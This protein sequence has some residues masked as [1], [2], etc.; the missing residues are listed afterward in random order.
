[1]AGTQASV[2]GNMLPAAGVTSTTSGTSGQGQQLM[3]NTSTVKQLSA[4]FME[5]SEF[6]VVQMQ[7]QTLSNAAVTN[8]IINN[9]GLG[10]SLELLV[11]GVITITNSNAGAQT[12][13]I[14]PEFPF[15][16][17]QNITVQ[18]NGQTVIHS[19]SG[20]ELLQIMSKRN[21][22][23]F[24]GEGSSAGVGYGQVDVRVPKALATLVIGGTGT[25]T[26]GNNI[27]GCASVSI[28]QGAATFTFSF[29]L[30][31]PFVFNSLD[32]ILIGL[33]PLQNNSVNCNVSIQCPTILG[34][35]ALAPLYGT[36]TY[37]TLT[38]TA[39]N[40]YPQYNFWAIPVPNNQKLYAWLTS[41]NYMLLS[42]GSNP[43]NNVGAKALN[44]SLPNNYF[45][46]AFVMIIRDSTTALVDP[47]SATVGID[48]LTLNYNGTAYIDRRKELMR[49]ARQTYYQNG[50]PGSLGVSLFD[51]TDA[52]AMP[53]RLNTSKWLNMYLSN[54]PQIQADIQASFSTVGT[55][56]VLREQLVPSQVQTV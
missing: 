1:M 38:S 7:T 35:T 54:N 14:S 6:N 3:P 33:L 13:N 12:L 43:I 16:L 51:L 53:N 23:M 21:K 4:L 10:Q 5:N 39:I 9:I 15:N 52:E 30:E 56:S 45:L 40:I 19:L 24:V 37:L 46:T 28:A 49:I 42:Q 48:N 31:L 29:Y 26:A 32:G 17:I 44:Y 34:T 27:V 11:S 50:F 41:Y 25:L 47:T 22:K 20:Y 36:L 8:F 2:R 18:F 55:F